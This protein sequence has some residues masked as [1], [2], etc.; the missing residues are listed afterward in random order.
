MIKQK[1]NT[2]A[3]PHAHSYLV[4]ITRTKTA[5]EKIRCSVFIRGVYSPKYVVDD[6]RVTDYEPL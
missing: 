3:E 1:K 6:I 4:P 5:S 2:Q